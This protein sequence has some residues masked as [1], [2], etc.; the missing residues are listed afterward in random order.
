MQLPCKV[1][2]EFKFLILECNE[3]LLPIEKIT[4]SNN[5]AALELQ[6]QHTQISQ[7]L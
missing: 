5:F 7:Y 4:N 3:G 6:I 1:G 2:K